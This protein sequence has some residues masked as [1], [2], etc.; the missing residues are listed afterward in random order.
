MSIIFYNLWCFMLISTYIM[1]F[2]YLN[3]CEYLGVQFPNIPCCKVR[4]DGQC[5]PDTDPCPNRGLSVYYDGF[6]PT[7]VANT[8]LATRSYTALSAL[9]ASPYDIAHLS[10][11]A[12]D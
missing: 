10:Q 9:D 8:V 5:I 7:E 4:P 1:W 6:H 12:D 2:C 11:V 3:C